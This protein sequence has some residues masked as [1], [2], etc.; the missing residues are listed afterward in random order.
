MNDLERI[1]A[2]VLAGGLGTRLRSLVADRP[3]VLADV[4]GRPFLAHLLDRL[5][6]AGFRRVV[7]LTGYLGDLV[8]KAFGPEYR[9]LELVYSREPEPLGTG[10]ALALAEPLF[11]SDPV[12]VMNG[13]SLVRL[14]YAGF[15]ARFI[16]SS[17]V[18]GLAAARVADVSRFGRLVLD[19]DGKVTA[20]EEKNAGVGP[21]FVNAGVYL[22][23]RTFLQSI[24]QGTVS[25]E[26]DVFPLFIGRGLY[27]FPMET[28]FLDI[29]VPDDYLRAE[30]YV[31]SSQR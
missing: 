28:D 15:L 9:G 29:G 11:R 27:G 18:A 2:A 3:K 7:L 4:G 21:G 26:K 12:M 30:G 14:D 24:P 5:A 1:D 20:F 17:A 22:L 13:D 8:E 6:E 31:G 10:G 25:L 23:S 19:P 16:E